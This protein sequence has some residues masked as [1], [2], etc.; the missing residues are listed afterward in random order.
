MEAMDEAK[1]AALETLEAGLAN[2][3]SPM[4]ILNDISAEWDGDPMELINMLV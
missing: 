3:D 1:Q 4:A 2:G